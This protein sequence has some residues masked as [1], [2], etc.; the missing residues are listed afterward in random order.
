MPSEG[1]CLYHYCSPASF[2]AI[3]QSGMLRFSDVFS[4]N[5][6]L[7]M[8][9][10]YRQWEVV[11][12]ELIDSVGEDFIDHVDAILSTSSL[13][14]L[15]LIASFSTDPDVLSQWRAYAKD[16]EGFCIGFDQKNNLPN[17]C[18][19]CSGFVRRNATKS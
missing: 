4:M 13:K 17:G 19:R 2:D 9:W 18:A 8:H 5:D 10:G 3:C 14:M 7:E 15:P 1:G 6:T 11:A 16:G 12:G